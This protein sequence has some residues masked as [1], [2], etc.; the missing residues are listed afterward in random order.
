MEKAKHQVRDKCTVI[1]AYFKFNQSLDFH[2]NKFLF[3]VSAERGEPKDWSKIHQKQFEKLVK[4]LPFV[5][6]C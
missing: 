5:M 6:N 1:V 3:Y 2:L 4:L